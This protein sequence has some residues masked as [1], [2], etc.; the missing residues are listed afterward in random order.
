MRYAV[1]AVAALLA[2]FP[3][4]ARAQSSDEVALQ[5]FSRV[6][7]AALERRESRRNRAQVEQNGEGNQARVAQEGS[8]NAALAYQE[9]AGNR[10][11]MHQYGFG[12]GANVAQVG[13]YNDACVI[14]FGTGLNADLQQY[15]DYGRAGVLQTQNGSRPIPTFACTIAERARERIARKMRRR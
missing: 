3:A 9:G 7:E 4:P 10:A 11:R 14:Q 12:N 8:E 13:D 15:G 1:S 2:I 5:I 6:A